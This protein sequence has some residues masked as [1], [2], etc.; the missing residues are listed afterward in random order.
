MP[1]CWSSPRQVSRRS[2]TAT[3]SS[4][5]STARRASCRRCPTCGPP[6]G[7][8]LVDVTTTQVADDWA[9]RWREF[10]RPVTIGARL[11]VRPPWTEPPRAAEAGLLDIVIDPNQA[12]GT[13]AHATTRLCL[14]A[15]LEL[16]PAQR[17]GPLVDLGCGLG[18][19]G[20]R[21]SQARLVAGPRG[22]PRAPR[23]RGRTRERPGQRRRASSVAHGDLLHD[24]PAATAPTVVANLLRP[25]LAHVAQHRIRRAAARR[26]RS[27]AACCAPRPTRSPRH[28]SAS[29]GCASA[30]RRERGEWAA[31]TLT[32]S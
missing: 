19:A 14:E 10:H 27:S 21:R 8:A 15:L 20:D 23:S 31:L 7:A 18:R 4:T 3:R 9:S 29:R 24:G 5:P 32:A 12:F 2:I 22:R 25:L 17:S 13:G 28:S 26:A 16:D 1:S 11:H 30:A 6:P